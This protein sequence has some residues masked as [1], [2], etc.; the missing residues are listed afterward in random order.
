MIRRRSGSKLL[1]VLLVA[2]CAG[3]G[4]TVYRGFSAPPEVPTEAPDDAAPAAGDDVAPLPEAAAF[5][6]P[7]LDDFSVIAERPLFS[8]TRRPA[9]GDAPTA[10][11]RQML[12]LTLIG[13]VLTGEER[14][15]IVTPAGQGKAVRLGV[16][17]SIRG[18]TLVELEPE[19]ATFERDGEEETLF[20]AFQTAPTPAKRQPGQQGQQNGATKND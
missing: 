13:V 18:W 20:L 15:A 8:P 9:E 17:D 1:T 2:A 6:M 5:E 4:W 10:A 12:D 11:P 19:R 7:P 16:G 3:L 14:I